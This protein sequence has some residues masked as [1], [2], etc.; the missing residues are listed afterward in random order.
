MHLFHKWEV[1]SSKTIKTG[2]R[3]TKLVCERMGGFT[4]TYYQKG[5]KGA[6]GENWFNDDV[7][8]QYKYPKMVWW[9]VEEYV[10]YR[11]EKCGICGKRRNRKIKTTKFVKRMTTKEQFNQGA[12]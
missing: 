2:R 5:K 8:K 1:V 12:K 6:I 3:Y 7:V 11:L 10:E 4:G 9:W